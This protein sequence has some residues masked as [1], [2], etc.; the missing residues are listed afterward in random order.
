M[1]RRTAVD[2]RVAAHMKVVKEEVGKRGALWARLP[3]KE[4]GQAGKS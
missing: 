3:H 4:A 2:E 1:I